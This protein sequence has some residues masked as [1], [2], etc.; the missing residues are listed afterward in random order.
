MEVLTADKEWCAEAYL[1][2]HY[3]DITASMFRSFVQK[4]LGFR[5]LND[6]LDFK[7][8]RH[9]AKQRKARLG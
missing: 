7:K 2:T 8:R 3:G 9:L 5:L 6:L 4:Y 1:E